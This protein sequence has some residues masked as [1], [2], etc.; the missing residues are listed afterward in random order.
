MLTVFSRGDF[1]FYVDLTV[2]SISLSV[3]GAMYN[4]TI[5]NHIENCSA[6]R[7]VTAARLIEN[8]EH[9]VNKKR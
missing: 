3:G 7:N 4:G 8:N 1:A 6:Q 9:N 5:G 2:L